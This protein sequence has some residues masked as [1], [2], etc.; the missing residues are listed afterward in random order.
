MKPLFLFMTVVFAAVQSFAANRFGALVEGYSNPKAG[1]SAAVSNVD[2]SFGHLKLNLASGNAAPV[3]AAG[4]TVAIFFTGNG[5]FTY[6]SDDPVEFPIVTRNTRGESHLKLDTSGK[7]ATISGPVSEVLLYAAGTPLPPIGS[8]GGAVGPE[9]AA[10]LEEFGRNYESSAAHGML[11]QN[12]GAPSTKY[13]RAE[14]RSG[15]DRL[16]YEFDE[17]ESTYETLVSLRTPDMDDKRVRERLY[18]GTLSSL[19]IGRDRKT[20]PTPPFLLTDVNY[21]LVGD[22]DNAKL[23]VAETIQRN[24]PRQALRFDMLHT[25]IPKAGAP[26]RH[27]HV[28]SI[29]DDQGHSLPFDHRNDDLVVGVEGLTGDTVKLK[30]SIDGDFLIRPNNDNFW[31]L[32]VMPW[33]PQPNFGGQYYTL[34]SLVKVK[35]PLIAFAPGA[36]VKRGEEGDYS[37]V[38]N[39][40]DKPVQFAVVH[41]GK[42]EYTEETRGPLTIRVASYG[43]KNERAAKQ[44]TNLAFTIIDYYEYFLGPFPF[45]EFNIVQVNTWGY[46]Q[47]PPGTMFITNEAFNSLTGFENQLFSQGI[48][49]RFAHEIAH[50]YWAHVVK[51]PSDEEQWLTESFAEYSAA[52]AIKK[53]QGAGKY[54]RLVQTW[55]LDAKQY[56]SVAPIPLANEIVEGTREAFLA[57]TFLLYAK[58]PYLLYVLHKELG[59]NAFLTFLKSFQKS[60]RWK[61]GATKDIAGLLQFMTKK[62]YMPFLDKYYWGTE[63]PD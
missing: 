51:M 2:Y 13:V 23:D 47:A 17:P 53:F 11:L 19:P 4:S 56:A 32:G 63:M 16:V 41:A 8:G 33:F 27:Y 28:L 5:T 6:V 30:F 36:T 18:G 61:F 44:L 46:G 35:K 54:D 42:Y 31:Q 60:L 38:E 29:T 26:E 52:L 40:I 3:T 39:V 55:K 50:Q 9:F 59:D 57:R 49:E 48:N 10:H 37:V 7:T 62:D 22:G 12:L 34:H 58:G 25:V 1:A 14:I 24:G 21:T 15:R 43:G 45:T 20:P